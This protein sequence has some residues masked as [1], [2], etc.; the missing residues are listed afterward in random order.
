MTVVN[1]NL[2]NKTVTLLFEFTG[3]INDNHT[4]STTAEFDANGEWSDSVRIWGY[5]K[6]GEVQI[7]V[8]VIKKGSKVIS[9]SDYITLTSVPNCD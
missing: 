2:K 4:F 1:S 8:G 9:Y 7:R 5:V 6:D 3:N